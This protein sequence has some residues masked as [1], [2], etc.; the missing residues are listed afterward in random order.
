GHVAALRTMNER[1]GATPIALARDPPIAQP[2]LHLLIAKPARAQVRGNRI[3]RLPIAEAVVLAGIDADAVRLERDIPLVRNRAA[4]LR[5]PGA[6]KRW[7]IG[8]LARAQSPEPR[9]RIDHLNDRQAILLREMEIPLVVRRH[10]HDGTF[11]VG[12]EH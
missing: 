6:G 9:A 2:P 1:N 3:D 8:A 12:H 5:A 7:I 10:A 4:G 11:A